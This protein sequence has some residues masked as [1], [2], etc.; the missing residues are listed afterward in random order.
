[1]CS[2]DSQAIG[3]LSGLQGLGYSVPDD[4][5]LVG[6]DDIPMVQLTSPPLTTIRVGRRALGQVAVQLLLGRIR[7]LDR[8]AIKATVGV[9]LIER[10]SVGPPRAHGIIPNTRSPDSVRPQYRKTHPVG[11]R[12]AVREEP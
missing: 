6:F 3:A 10:A 11:H 8:P 2:N 5:S 7:A 4:L 9:T 1:M 12:E